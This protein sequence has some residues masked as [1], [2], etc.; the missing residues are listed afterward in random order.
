MDNSTN[1]IGIGAL[2]A[3]AGSYAYTYNQIQNVQ[4]EITKVSESI[5][6]TNEGLKAY[7]ENIKESIGKIATWS[8]DI[9]KDIE[10]LHARVL[11]IEDFL[12]QQLRYPVE[13]K[14]PH[15]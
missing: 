12:I 5:N 15:Q 11:C 6:K 7:D 14:P 8:Q 3:A 13:T 1:Y 4:K 9:S 2:A 10:E